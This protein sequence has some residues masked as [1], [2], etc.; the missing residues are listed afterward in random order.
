MGLNPGKN[1]ATYRQIPAHRKH[2]IF[3][4]DTSDNSNSRPD[5]LALTSFTLPDRAET[6]QYQD[7]LETN[8]RLPP[9]LLLKRLATG[10]RVIFAL[11]DDRIIA[12]LWLA[13]DGQFIAETGMTLTLRL[14]EFVTFNAVTLPEWRSRGLSTALN[15][16]AYEYCAELGRTVQL[17]WRSTTNRSALRVAEK[18]QQKPVGRMS[19]VWLL[20]HRI[21]FR[22]DQENDM[23]ILMSDHR[24]H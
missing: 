15:Q 5:S 13:F 21:W 8:F 2:P 22:Y 14:N 9:A 11:Q 20:G 4:R 23:K 18:L 3:S 10:K 12:I 6:L 16:V 19:C 1:Q 24:R 17:T 7:E